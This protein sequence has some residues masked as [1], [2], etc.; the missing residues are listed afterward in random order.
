LPSTSAAAPA[1]IL[2]PALIDVYPYRGTSGEKC[3]SITMRI[4]LCTEA[5]PKKALL[6]WHRKE[7][8]E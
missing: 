4:D 3:H 8:S 2:V 7:L 6:G 1:I 5:L